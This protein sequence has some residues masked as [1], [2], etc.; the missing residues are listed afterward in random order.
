MGKNAV[1]ASI[2]CVNPTEYFHGALSGALQ[3]LN[4][5]ASEHAQ[6]YLVNMLMNFISMERLYPVG[7]SG[8]RSE[9]L[10]S[11]LASA[12]EEESAEAR[13]ERLRQLGDFSLYIAGFF[14]NSFSRKLVDV[15]YYIGMGGSAYSNVASMV[16]HKIKM[17]LFSELAD[18]FPLFVDAFAQISEESSFKQE[19]SQALLRMYDLWTKTG[20]NRLAKQLAKAG[21]VPATGAIKSRNTDENSEN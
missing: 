2:I 10:T 1:K 11:Q 7:Q 21:I 14:S 6:L 20:S 4:I 16:E 8:E 9:T 13:R 17:N 12:L 19:N 5:K 3:T 18:K 15:D